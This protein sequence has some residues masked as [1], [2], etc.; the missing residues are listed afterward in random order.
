MKSRKNFC[1]LGDSSLTK[2]YDAVSLTQPDMSLSIKDIIDRFAF[3]G[4]TPLG[5]MTFEEPSVK[6]DEKLFNSVD[7]E[8]LDIAEL[9]ELALSLNER[10]NWLRSQPPAAPAAVTP[11]PSDADDPPENQKQ[12]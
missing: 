3:V 2:V 12:A 10:A 4:D 8:R 9:E 6:D 1:S 7:V 11:S 5:M